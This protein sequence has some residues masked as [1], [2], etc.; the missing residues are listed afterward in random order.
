MIKTKSIVFI[1]VLFLGL[2]TFAQHSWLM[3]Q[4]SL[5]NSSN[6]ILDVHGNAGYRSNSLDREMMDILLFGGYISNELSGRQFDRMDER[7]T[8]GGNYHG[9]FRVILPNDSAFGLADWGWQASVDLKGHAEIG[10]NKDLFH[11]IFDGNAPDYVGETANFNDTWIDYMEYQ[12]VGFGMW[13]RSTQSGFILSV[14]NGQQFERLN[15]FEGELYTAENVDSLS[16]LYHG[17]WV[18]S[19]TA[20]S[21]FGVGNGIGFALDGRINVPLKGDKGIVSVAINDFGVVGWNESTLRYEADS[22]FTYEGVP[23]DDIIDDDGNGLP[24]FEDSLHYES[25]K[26]RMNRWLPGTIDAQL[27]HVVGERD[28]FRA[29]MRFRPV[30]VYNPLLQL[31]YYYNLPSNTLLGAV[32]SVGGYGGIRVGFEA[33]QWFADRFFLALGI[34]DVYGPIAN[35]GLGMHGNIRLTYRIRNND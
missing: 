27:M 4:D 18:R 25:E 22:L 9:G 8:L 34:Q 31:G 26:G 11:L 7:L 6:V 12:K 19:D 16:L 5:I 20:I 24:N 29:A 13:H 33:E 32:A 35:E 17:V 10:A 30:N 15:V 28:F 2:Q 3:T 21:G 1:C 14:V 23:L